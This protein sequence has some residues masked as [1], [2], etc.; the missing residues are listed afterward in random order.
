M[1][2]LAKTTHSVPLLEGRR[3]RGHHNAA[4]WKLWLQA[5][6][7][8]LIGASGFEHVETFVQFAGFPRSGHSLIGS[9]LDAHANA[10][11]SHELDTMGLLRKGF[12]QADIFRLIDRQALDFTR[13]ERYWNGFS[14][15]VPGGA[16]LSPAPKI[17]VI[18]DKKGDVAVR[19]V[20]RDP[21]LLDRLAALPRAAKKWILILRN[22]FDNI[23][24]MSLRKGRAY[25]VLRTTLERGENFHAELKKQ[26][27]KGLIA[28]TALE[29][30]IKDYAEL[31][32][33]VAVMH[34][35][36][37]PQDWL[38]V[39]Y[40]DF[41]HEPAA[42]LRRLLSFLDLPA[43]EDYVANATALVNARVNRSRDLIGWTD[44]QC[45]RVNALIDEYSFLDHYR[46]DADGAH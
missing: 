6:G 7:H 25:D 31:C 12:T 46:R 3:S 41:A 34:E 36:T 10:R 33:T 38:E 9:I 17:R 23:A 39:C 19:W 37:A 2:R 22:P 15:L 21:A 18:G 24:T 40:E 26:Q 16:H 45:A 1:R 44:A 5:R 32:R 43:S 35:R 28:D 8:S 42:G 14:Y 27:A 20:A 4:L 13:H 30:E 11:I 29:S